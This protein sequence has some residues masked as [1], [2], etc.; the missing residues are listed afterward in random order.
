[1]DKDRR[2]HKRLPLTLAIAQPLRIE[3]YTENTQNT[4]P[5][6]I[7]NISAA[8]MALV[9]FSELPQDTKIEFNLDFMGIKEKVSG[10]VVR[11]QE[12]AEGVFSV[13]VKFDKPV[14]SLKEL[15]ADMAE[16]FEYFLHLS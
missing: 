16:D 9:V 7:V 14:E 8:G 2:S 4:T 10:M 6:I 15:I 13:G 3:I 5:G 1:M 12:K 11:E